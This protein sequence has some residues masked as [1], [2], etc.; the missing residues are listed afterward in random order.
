MLCEIAGIEPTYR[1]MNPIKQMLR[2]SQT[3]ALCLK[4]KKINEENSSHAI[5]SKIDI[6]TI[7]ITSMIENILNAFFMFLPPLSFL[8]STINYSG[9]AL[10]YVP[11][12]N[13]RP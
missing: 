12:D 9:S 5:A 8:R 10:T 4:H 7:S 1:T 6:N 13:R 2:S 3:G 11:P